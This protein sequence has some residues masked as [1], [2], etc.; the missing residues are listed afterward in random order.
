MATKQKTERLATAAA[1][2]NW[3]AFNEYLRDC[4]EKEALSALNRERD[5]KARVQYLLR[6]HARWN[7]LRA[8]RERVE[9]LKESGRG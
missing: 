7:R 8:Q 1:M 2:A 9:L 4:S 6:A 5:G 3:P